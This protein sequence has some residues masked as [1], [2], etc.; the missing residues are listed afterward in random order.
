MLIHL[1]ATVFT[2]NVATVITFV[3]L[4]DALQL[5][6]QRTTQVLAVVMISHMFLNLKGSKHH[7]S[8]GV[9]NRSAPLGCRTEFPEAYDTSVSHETRV[10]RPKHMSSLVGT[11]GNELIHS[12]VSDHWNFDEKVSKDYDSLF[13]CPNW[14]H[15]YS[16]F[17][18]WNFNHHDHAPKQERIETN[19]LPIFQGLREIPACYRVHPQ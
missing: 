3:T 9:E 6:L 17:I 11:L 19:L 15:T 8:K 12:S 5:L 10:T 1:S 7:G 13:H 2:L 18:Y 4:P 14:L 16:P